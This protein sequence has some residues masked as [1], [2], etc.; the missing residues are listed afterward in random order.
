MVLNSYVLVCDYSLKAT[1]NTND[2]EDGCRLTSH[3]DICLPLWMSV[4]MLTLTWSSIGRHTM[5]IPVNNYC[6]NNT[7]QRTST[8]HT[9]TD[10]YNIRE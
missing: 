2:D 3:D 1:D 6:N 5:Y 10:V 4:T 8:C 7:Q 9:V